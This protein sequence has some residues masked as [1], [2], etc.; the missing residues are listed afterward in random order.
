MGK[1]YVFFNVE[2]RIN[3]KKNT[4]VI[5]HNAVSQ[6]INLTDV[7]WRQRESGIYPPP[8]PVGVVNV[9]RRNM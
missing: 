7:S 6:A 2:N 9:D 5:K 1:H 3:I 8:N 4:A